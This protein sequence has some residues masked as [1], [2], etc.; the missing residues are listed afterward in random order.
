MNK[1][2]FNDFKVNSYKEIG[3]TIIIDNRYVLKKDINYDHSIYNYLV[4]KEFK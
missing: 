4:N 3:K 2:I 1:E